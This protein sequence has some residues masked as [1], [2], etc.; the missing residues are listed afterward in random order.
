QIGPALR[1]LALQLLGAGGEGGLALQRTTLLLDQPA[2][3]LVERADL[4]RQLLVLAGELLLEALRAGPQFRLQIA[5]AAL[6][7]GE[8]LPLTQ[9]PLL[10]GDPLALAGEGAGGPLEVRV[11]PGDVA[12]DILPALPRLVVLGAV[13]LQR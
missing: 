11:S 4:L 9:A 3:L 1:E 8:P 10:S 5:Q 7:L 12:L 6:V 13:G 2:P